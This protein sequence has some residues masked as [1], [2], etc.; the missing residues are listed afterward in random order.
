MPVSTIGFGVLISRVDPFP[1]KFPDPDFGV[2]GPF[3]L[4]PYSSMS[5]IFLTRPFRSVTASNKCEYTNF[6]GNLG[7]FYDYERFLQ[8]S[9]IFNFC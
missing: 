6:Y 8:F 7:N 2:S 1:E 5:N 4:V 9:D 3:I